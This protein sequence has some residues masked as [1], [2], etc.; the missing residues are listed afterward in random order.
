MTVVRAAGGVVRR[1]G[2]V[3]LVHRPRYDDWT[4]PKGKAD[5]GETDEDCALREVE[6]ETGLRCE[7]GPELAPT[8]YTDARGR[9]KRVRWWRMEPVDDRGFVPNDEVDELRW[10]SPAEAAALLSYGRDLELL[11]EGVSAVLLRHAKAGDRDAWHGD[12]AARALDERGLLQAQALVGLLASDGPR[13]IVSSPYVRCVETVEPLAAA[14]GVAVELD[15]RLA[16]GAG[17]AAAL[18][19]LVELG[20]GVAC[21]HG[22]V[23]EEILGF[24][25]KKGAG[26]LV[27]LVGGEPVVARVIPAP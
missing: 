14:L 24:G 21:T 3:L 12:D 27:D 4:F 16:E 17:R 1:D 26:V 7:L 11:T 13:R 20:A 22:D 8:Q 15:D 9:P 2:R 5:D 23:V 19:L 6:E 10:A 18:A 25:L